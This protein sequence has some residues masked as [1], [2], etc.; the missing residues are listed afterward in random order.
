MINKTRKHKKNENKKK[1]RGNI[2]QGNLR[3]W[4]GEDS[5]RASLSISGNEHDDGNGEIRH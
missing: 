4:R 2:L 3:K 5:E 1:E